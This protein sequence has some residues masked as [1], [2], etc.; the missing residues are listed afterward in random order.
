MEKKNTHSGSFGDIV[1]VYDLL[2]FLLHWPALIVDLPLQSAFHLL[3]FCPFP[4]H[5]M[6]NESNENVIACIG[7]A[8]AVLLCDFCPSDFL[9]VHLYSY[10]LSPWYIVSVAARNSISGHIH[11]YPTPT[12]TH[13][14][15][16]ADA[17][18]NSSRPM[19]KGM[20]AIIGCRLQY[21]VHA[22]IR[23]WPLRVAQLHFW[24]PLAFA[25]VA[26]WSLIFFFYTVFRRPLLVCHCNVTGESSSLKHLHAGIVV[27]SS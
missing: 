13:T 24:L 1:G 6:P 4:Y 22:M 25:V 5:V 26:A 8:L 18:A 3:V 20:G 15:V 23:P 7:C 14:N 27:T 2:L 12:Y 11:I 17:N 9:T 10:L 16:N 21:F 19:T